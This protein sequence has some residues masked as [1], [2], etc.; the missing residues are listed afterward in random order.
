MTRTTPSRGAA[1]R[2]LTVAV[3]LVLA[4]GLAACGDSESAGGAIEP[5]KDLSAVT[6]TGDFGQEPTWEF[7]DRVSVDEPESK[8][9]IEGD[10]EELAEGDQ[11]FSHL[12]IANGY[13]KKEVYSDFDGD[14][15]VLALDSNGLAGLVDAAK[16]QPLGSRLLIALS[17]EDAFG[18]DGNPTLGI[19]NRDTAVFVVDLISTLASEPSGKD[20]K[21]ASWMPALVEKDGVPTGF[22]FAGT[23]SPTGELQQGFLIKGDGPVVEKKQTV[24]VNYLGQVFKGKQPFDESYSSGQPLSRK[25]GVGELIKGWD[26]TVVGAPVGSR[27]VIAVPPELGYGEDGNKDS[28]IKGTDTL[29]FVIDI[30]AAV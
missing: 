22:D 18:P 20:V 11:V 3:A 21:P 23:P 17:A 9:L 24:Y 29:Y 30:L 19:G 4:G 28:N 15:Q 25:I 26:Q 5:G 10:G 6:V 1:R 7:S 13:D 27:L 8:V 16:G 12:A 14:P 2:A